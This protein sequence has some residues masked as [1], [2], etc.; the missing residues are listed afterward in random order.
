MDM[1]IQR[2]FIGRG[3]EVLTYGVYPIHTE[4]TRGHTEEGN[5][6]NKLLKHK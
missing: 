4:Y 1:L 2:R 5:R 6:T 3:L